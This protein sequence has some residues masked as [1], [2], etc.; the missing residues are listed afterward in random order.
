[1]VG[2]GNKSAL[3]S[4]ELAKYFAKSEERLKRFKK[5]GTEPLIRM[6]EGT[7]RTLAEKMRR[8]P[9]AFRILGKIRKEVRREFLREDVVDDTIVVRLR[10]AL[11]TLGALGYYSEKLHPLGNIPTWGKFLTEM[12]KVPKKRRKL[13]AEALAKILSHARAEMFEREF[14]PLSAND[15]MRHNLMEALFKKDGRVRSGRR[16]PKKKKK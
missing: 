14:P 12:T 6:E 4:I 8:D 7:L 13:I 2:K 5:R 11:A 16:K 1:M 10:D 9:V 15:K 3:A